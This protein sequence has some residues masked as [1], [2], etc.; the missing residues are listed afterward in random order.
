MCNSRTWNGE[1]YTESGEYV[2]SFETV[3]HCD[4]IV[5]LRLTVNYDQAFEWYDTVCDVKQWNESV[6]TESGD[7]VQHF[8]TVHGCDSVVTLHLV[9]NHSDAAEFTAVSCYQYIWEGVEY[10]QSGD[11]TRTFTNQHGCDSVVTMH[12][13]INDT[14]YN[15]FEVEACNSYTWNNETY[16]ASGDYVQQFVSASECDSIV[17]LHLTLYHDKDTTVR[18]DVCDSYA[19]EWSDEVFTESGEHIY[20]VET[21][22]HCD[23]TITLM[24]TVR[25]GTASELDSAVCF[26]ELPL[27]WNGVTF[28][29]GG[30]QQTTLSNAAGCDSLVTMH[31]TIKPNTYA[32]LYDT[33]VQNLLPYDT[34]GMHFTDAGSQTVTITNSAGCDSVVTMNL[35]VLENM[36]VQVERTVCE[37]ELPLTWNG[38]AFTQ[39][40]TQSTTLTASSGVDSVVV[41][42]LHVNMNTSSTVQESVVENELPHAFN[43][44]TFNAPVTG[45]DIVIPN[46]DGCDSVITYTLNV[47]YN[48]KDT[49]ERTIC[50]N[51]LP[52][53]WNNATFNAAGMQDVTLQTSHGAD[54]LLTMVLQVNYNTY[55]TLYDTIVENL[56]PYDTLGMHFTAAGTLTDTIANANGCDS[57]VTMSLHVWMSVVN[58]DVRTVCENE[59]PYQWD[60]ITFTQAGFSDDTLSTSHGADSILRKELIVNPNTYSTLY[61]TIVENS[62]PYDTLG[63]HFTDAGTMTD[64]IAN[65]NGCDSVVTM[66]LHVWHNVTARADSTICEGDLPLVWNG[67]TFG[68]TDTLTVTLLTSHGADS[69]LTMYLRVNPNTYATLHDTVVENSLPYDTLG[70][71]FTDAGTQTATI[72][73]A[74]GCD[75]IV[76]MSLHVW[77]N[78]HNTIDSI[79]C[80]NDLPIVWNGVMF[81]VAMDSTIVL[82]GNHGVDSVL[83]MR[84]EVIPTDVTAFEETVCEGDD[85]MGHGFVVPG[86]QTVNIDGNR[87]SIENTYQNRF[88][89][90]SIVRLEL[91]IIDTSIYIEPLSDFCDNLYTTLAAVSTMTDYLWSTGASSPNIDV[92][93]HGIYTVTATQGECRATASFTVEKCDLAIYLPNAITPGKLDGRN[94]C[95]SLPERYQNQMDDFEITIFNRWGQPVF[96]SKDKAFRWYGEYKDNV[97]RQNVYNYIIYYTDNDRFHQRHQLKGAITVL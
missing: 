93:V 37:N 24:L 15:N 14:I 52:Y 77:Y 25:H 47:W 83:T 87:L 16:T 34:L 10:T 26:S 43:G 63:M 78:V 82:V 85:Y 79:V 81:A 91:N 60:N 51:E 96:H 64:T 95:F 27:T 19:S 8:Q 44:H 17:T 12:L 4:S 59:L 28:E 75:S 57:V 1:T 41:M 45:E 11:V 39:A 54:S 36:E 46:A 13:T 50:E 48:V 3:N 56:L 68:G 73:N 33:I 53:S 97:Y 5:T 94:D 89:C 55:S 66:S 30:T 23:S 9:V 67:R 71:H 40:G 80:E 90:D 22:H 86:S 35:F 21:S 32:V 29:D 69:V 74:N 84:L 2:Q 6:Y 62:L 92:T 58:A 49:V 61:D 72:A 76:T 31:L 88:G 20:H 18:R 42:T 7:Y 38:V 65:A 70:M